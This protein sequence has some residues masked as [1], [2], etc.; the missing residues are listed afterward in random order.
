MK[1]ILNLIFFLAV[2]TF[3][4]GFAQEKKGIKKEGAHEAEYNANTQEREHGPEVDM[5]NRE[6]GIDN[7]ADDQSHDPNSPANT[8]G[9]DSRMASGAGST[10]EPAENGTDGTNTMPRA[11]LNTAGSPVPGGK[12][13]SAES[14][15]NQPPREAP[16]RNKPGNKRP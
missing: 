3:T 8:S 9:T 12:S 2:M 1:N 7:N 4:Q 13:N 6:E 15:T 14:Q 16:V 11:T 10:A 5:R